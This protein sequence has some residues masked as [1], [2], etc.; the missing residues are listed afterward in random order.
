MLAVSHDLTQFPGTKLLLPR[1]AGDTPTP[2]SP[3]AGFLLRVL[4]SPEFPLP[5]L[6]GG[7]TLR[8][9]EGVAAA[10]HV[11]HTWVLSRLQRGDPDPYYYHPKSTSLSR[12]LRA[13][14]E[15]PSPRPALT[16]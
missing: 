12:L 5:P 2:R 16:R 11:V 8:G 9:P 6:I 15:E 3:R 13:G 7:D 10:S 14:E 1:E 4:D